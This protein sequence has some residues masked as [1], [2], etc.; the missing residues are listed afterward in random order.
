M[1]FGN[2]AHNEQAQPGSLDV[3]ERAAPHAMKALEDPL[4]IFL[5]DSYAFVFHLQENAFRSSGVSR[6][7]AHIDVIAGILDGIFEDIGNRGAQILETAQHAHTVSVMKR[8]FVA[9]GL[10]R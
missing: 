9:H 4:E 6:R 8:L 2:R 5:C 7:T 1:L 3:S 10:W